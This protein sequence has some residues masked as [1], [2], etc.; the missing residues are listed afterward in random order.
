M[1]E[2]NIATGDTYREKTGQPYY[3]WEAGTD[4]NLKRAEYQALMDILKDSDT[5]KYRKDILTELLK[6]L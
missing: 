3:Y 2:D 5:D 4:L 1:T 6:D